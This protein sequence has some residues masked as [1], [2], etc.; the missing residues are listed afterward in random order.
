MSAFHWSR[1]FC[2]QVLLKKWNHCHIG[3]MQTDLFSSCSVKA[4]ELPKLSRITNVLSRSVIVLKL[5]HC[6][7]RCLG[8]WRQ[9][10]TLWTICGSFS[11]PWRRCKRVARGRS[12][13]T[14]LLVSDSVLMLRRQC[15]LH[16]CFLLLIRSKNC[17]MLSKPPSHLNTGT[18]LVA[19]T[20]LT[21]SFV[22]RQESALRNG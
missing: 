8:L 1:H 11:W 9:M 21:V 22:H 14:N 4:V 13:K 12:M 17:K 10:M 6:Q 15:C 18:R 2:H 20:R 3:Q 19:S 16:L 7:E 5:W